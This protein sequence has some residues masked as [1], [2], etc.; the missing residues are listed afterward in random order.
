MGA[1]NDGEIRKQH[2]ARRLPLRKRN[3]PN[4]SNAFAVM[5]EI[6]SVMMDNEALYDAHRRSPGAKRVNRLLVQ[7]TSHC[8]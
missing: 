4:S 5:H 8:G 3:N 7:I 6:M 1:R 2:T